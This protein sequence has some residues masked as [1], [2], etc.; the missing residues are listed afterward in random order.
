MRAPRLNLL[1][2]VSSIASF[3]AGCGAT[4][5]SSAP[6]VVAPAG[7]LHANHLRGGAF[8]SGV[9]CAGCHAPTGFAVDFSQNPMVM[10][11]GATFDPVAK[12]CSNVMCHGSF[13]FRGVQGSGAKVGWTGSALMTCDSCHAMPPTGHPAMATGAT[14]ASCNACHS[15]TVKPDGSINVSGGAHLNGMAEIAA[16]S[17]MECHGDASRIPN[18]PGTDIYLASSPPA[19]SPGAP[20]S[21][22]GAH[23]GHVNPMPASA[24]MPPLACAECHQVPTDDVHAMAPPARTVVFGT[25]ASTGAAS[26]TWVA[27][28]AGCAATYCHGNF[29]FN[30][31]SGST[32]TPIWTDTAPIGCASCH[33]MPPTGHPLVQ[34]TSAVSCSGCHPTS[35]DASGAIVS[36]GAHLDGKADV[37]ALGCTSCHGDEGR[38]GNMA[39]ADVNLASSPPAASAGAP[40]YSTG[41]HLAHLNPYQAGAFMGPMDCAECHV[42]PSDFAHATA[43]PAQKVVFG[44]LSRTGG[45][46]PTFAAGTAGCAAS[47]CHGNFDFNG[48]KGALATPIWTDPNPLTCTSCHGMP[49]TGHVAVA[50]PASSAGCATCHPSALNTDGSVNL[51]ERG[52]MNG[53]ADVASLGCTGCHGD[54]GR[55]PN[56]PGTDIDLTS[57]PPVSSPGAPAYSAGA[58]EGHVNPAGASAVMNPIACAECHVIP[59]DATHARNPPAQ[60]VT[61]GLLSRTGGATPTFVAGTAGC[62]ASYCHGNFTYNGVSGSNA[63]PLWTSTAPLACTGCH[64]MPPTGHPPLAGSITAASCGACHPQTVDAA[65]DIL[66]GGAHLNGLADVAALGC[67]ACHGDEMRKP[68]LPGTD[69][70]LISAPP[71]APPNAPAFAV[72]AHERHVNPVDFRAIMGPIACAECHVVPAD[73]A[74]ASTPPLA[75]VVFGPIATAGGATPTFVAGSAGCAASYCHGNFS[76]NAVS[77]TSTTPVWTDTTP[78]TC[79]SC[80]EMPPVGHLAVAAPVVAASCASCHPAAVNADGSINLADRG[81]LNG[82]ADVTALGC[83]SC[84]GDDTRTGNL[85]GTDV[86][87]GSAPPAAPP[88]APAFAV[89]AHA[90][91]VNPVA[92]TALMRPIGCA[93]CHPVPVDTVHATYPPAQG[94]TFGPLARSGGARP[95]WNEASAG[96][97]TSYCHGSFNFNGVTGSAAIAIWTSTTA[98]SCTSCHA[99]PP[100]GHLAVAAPVNAAS[101]A[102]CHPSAVNADGT[103]N[104]V[105]WG[106]LNGRSDTVSLGCTDCHGDSTR[107]GN[108]AGADLHLAS[109]P[110]S[111]PPGAPAYA[112]GAHLGHVNPATATAVRSPIAC[113]ECHVVPADAGHATR[114]PA[115]RV[116]FG[117]LSRTGGAVPFWSSG[118]TGCS[119]SYCHGNF[120]YNGIAGD[121]ATPLWTST[122]ALTCTSC[123]GMPPPDHVP[124][125]APATSASCAGCHPK[126][127]NANGS[128]N[129]VDR[130]HLNGLAD[131]SPMGCTSCHGDATRTGNLAGVDIHL[132]SAPPVAPPNASSTVVGAHL[133]H[134]NPTAATALMGPISCS[135]CHVVPGNSTHATSPPAQKV[136]FGALARTGGAAPTFT[137]GTLGC[138]ATYCHGNFAFGAVTGGNA[139]PTWTSTAAM[140]CTSCHGMP[141]TGHVAVVAPVTA[142]SCAICH[143]RAVNA[144]GTMNL[145]ARG[146]LNGLNDTS[147]VG[148]TTCHGDAA[149]KGNLA[150][151]DLNLAAAPPVAPAGAP[152]YAVGAHTG[153]A[154]PTTASYLMPPIACSGCHPVPTDSAHATAPPPSPVVFGTQARTGGAAPTFDPVTAGC[155][156][157]YCHGNFK[158]GVVSG[159]NATA[160][161]SSTAPL[162]CTAC[163]AMPPTG[164]PTYTGT[165]T[166]VSC[167]QCHPQSVNANGTIKQGG[168]HVNGK[169]DGGGCTG[170]HGDPPTTGKHTISDHRNLR[171]DK[172]HP[173]GFTSAAT[174][175]PFH[176]NTRTDLGTQAGYRCNNVASLVG[177]TTGQ[178]RTCANSCHGSERW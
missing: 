63:T 165:P 110:P 106:H 138:A 46:A 51:V 87:L 14:P 6:A 149:R 12:T 139:T 50:A 177:C 125:S 172:C 79:T 161:W 154:N 48:V 171:C 17:C 126:A 168:G 61:F 108:L 98:L 173:T 73:S 90:G 68:L 109:A 124:V 158:L 136:V 97:S 116:T 107:K 141:P 20:P 105:D 140:T 22:V 101:C 176:N 169:A 135:E 85:P 57:S 145:T 44:A 123:H 45:A 30:G 115:Q 153:H 4:T 162:A 95:A 72:G 92:A 33:G 119:A 49:P 113:A 78:M 128:L 55:I 32:V 89:G 26:P 23:L 41:A 150:G 29:S 91:H 88:G 70:N 21:S 53:K 52:H 58:H 120:S 24:V 118:S 148:C 28:T 112:E 47:Y 40:A 134:L 3:I 147:A 103:I 9:T 111:A 74:H 56:L 8:S 159:S 133:G 15:G 164:H 13:T 19:S 35:V 86:N 2:V 127:F 54:A 167:F 143:P 69:P 175:A 166:A 5:S 76:F 144:N 84:H 137:A 36:G 67:T 129:L 10:A 27:G 42:V 18:V 77:G 96:C 82:K 7:A 151:T 39:G 174:V 178:T 65:G 102:R 83:T 117:A 100:A 152:S 104:R 130:G 60:R 93:E 146:H 99:M 16:N 94:V 11:A 31:V 34:G 59:T 25:L 37:A 163:H 43:P 121:N 170:C 64:G 142:A 132:T 1:L 66:L 75:R 156:A 80:H 71:V 62:A 155:S 38:T 122:A 81:H 157:T 160:V 114:P 131:T